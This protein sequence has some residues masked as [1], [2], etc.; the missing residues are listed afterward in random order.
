MDK[1]Q[2][3][4]RGMGTTCTLAAIRET[5]LFL[6]QV[7]DS[8][9]YLL[10]AGDLHQLTTDH[11]WVEEAVAQG[12]LT[13]EQARVHPNRNVITRAIGIH[14]TV[15]VDTTAMPIQEGDI[16]LICS[17]GLNSMIDDDQIKTILK[18]NQIDEVCEGLIEGANDS[19]GHD[20]TTVIV[21]VIE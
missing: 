4:H 20:N 15:E 11:S 8:R 7:G 14:P 9:A 21:A 18:S 6:S 1:R 3:I 10:R 13:S 12:M 19:G 16:L 17:D 2:P 5:Q